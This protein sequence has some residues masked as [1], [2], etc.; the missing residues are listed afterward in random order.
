MW[1]FARGAMTLSALAIGSYAFALLAV[2]GMR[3][4]FLQ[5]RFASL[6]LA[7]YAHL[8]GSGLALVLGPLQLHPRLR[9]R[10]VA[11]HRALGVTYLLAVFAGGSAGFVLALVSQGGAIAH[12]GFAL[13]A[14]A[15]LGATGT[16]FRR[17]W[18]GDRVSHGRWMV[19]SFA[20][21][22]AAVTLRI[23]LPVSQAVGIP[24]DLAY[25]AIAW[26]CW[27]PNLLFAEWLLARAAPLPAGVTRSL[28]S[29][30]PR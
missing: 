11:L 4:P 27:L 15:W 24:F 21:T 29:T 9:A 2:P 19:R 17:I 14:V 7:A 6:P 13:L 22:F 12:A 1:R 5:E 18:S 28:P 26:L 8:A 16:A 20:L 10:H 3:A 25:P 23:Q 30:S